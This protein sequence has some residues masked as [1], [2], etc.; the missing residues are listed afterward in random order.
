MHT[1]SRVLSD[2]AQGPVEPPENAI[3][4]Q[5][6]GEEGKPIL[7]S[8][9]VGSAPFFLR[10]DEWLARQQPFFAENL[11]A[12]RTQVVGVARGRPWLSDDRKDF[13]E[14]H[15]TR[16]ANQPMTPYTGYFATMGRGATV[17]RV[18]A[19]VRRRGRQA[20]RA[21]PGHRQGPVRRR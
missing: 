9:V 14:F 20:G 19:Q 3:V 7:W 4:P 6:P 8:E 1:L 21:G 15:R 5:L 16:P 11:F 18:P 12:L 2:T 13:L 17:R 10:F